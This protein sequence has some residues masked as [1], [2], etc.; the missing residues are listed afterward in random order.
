MK[1]PRLTIREL[2]RF[3]A[4]TALFVCNVTQ[5]WRADRLALELDTVYMISD[6]ELLEA[7]KTI[8][9][10]RAKLAECLERHGEAE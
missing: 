1:L 4:I 6:R 8:A 5:H 3:I 2:V 7:E 9:E 10:L